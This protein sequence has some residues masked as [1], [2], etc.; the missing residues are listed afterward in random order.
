M[1]LFADHGASANQIITSTHQFEN[2]PKT[3][4]K[5]NMIQKLRKQQCI[6]DCSIL[7]PSLIWLSH[8]ILVIFY[9]SYQICKY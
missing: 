9:D 4:N 8:T 7:S 5:E 1:A 6:V 3:E 2:V